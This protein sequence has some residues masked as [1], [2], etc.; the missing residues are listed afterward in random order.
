MACLLAEYIG[1]KALGLRPVML[2]ILTTTPPD[3]PLLVPM[4][5]IANSVP[6]MVPPCQ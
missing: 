2:E 6:L 1:P 4:R 5:S 3:P